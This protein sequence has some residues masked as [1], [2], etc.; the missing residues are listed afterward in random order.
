MHKPRIFLLFTV[1]ILSSFLYS[2]SSNSDDS[3]KEET[4][5][6]L[7]IKVLNTSTT[8]GDISQNGIGDD[9]QELVS[10]S[11]SKALINGTTKKELFSSEALEQANGIFRDNTDAD[12]NS[13]E[14]SIFEMQTLDKERVLIVA[15]IKQT[16][17]VTGTQSTREGKIYFNEEGLIVGFDLSN[18]DSAL[19]TGATT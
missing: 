5:P 3:Q 6:V 19:N 12:S 13:V 15:D 18:F 14:L 1:L 4:Q 8:I 10:S 2:C 7:G 17:E 9:T 11:I 16:L